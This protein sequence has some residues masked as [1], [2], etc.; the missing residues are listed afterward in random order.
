MPINWDAEPVHQELRALYVR[1][2]GRTCP[3]AGTTLAPAVQDN[4]LTDCYT[5]VAVIEEVLAQHAVVGDEVGYTDGKVYC[6]P[7]EKLLAVRSEVESR[8]DDFQKNY[9]L[10]FLADI[11]VAE[12]GQFDLYISEYR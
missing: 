3:K 11:D 1:P 6:V 9:S 10:E 7:H 8:I 2:V 4:F 12:Q 5:D